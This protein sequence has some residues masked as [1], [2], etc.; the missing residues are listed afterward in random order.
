MSPSAGL[1]KAQNM[2]SA[3]AMM[4]AIAAKHKR[5]R[6]IAKERILAADI[7][8]SPIARIYTLA[9][10]ARGSLER[11]SLSGYDEDKP[12]FWSLELV[13]SAYM[14]RRNLWIILGMIVVSL[15]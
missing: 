4:V 5:V 8:A 1:S 14:P 9:I 15:V 7:G 10:Y 13:E 6:K 3:A 12:I 11:Q 2:P